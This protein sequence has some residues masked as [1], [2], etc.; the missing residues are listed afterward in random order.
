[1]IYH[2]S[3]KNSSFLLFRFF[4]F[5]FLFFLCKILGFFLW[6]CFIFFILKNLK[7]KK[8]NTTVVPLWLNERNPLH[9][10]LFSLS[11]T[12]QV[13]S[14]GWPIVGFIVILIVLSNKNQAWIN[15]VCI[16]MSDCYCSCKANSYNVVCKTSAYLSSCFKLV[17]FFLLK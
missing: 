15:S 6:L 11:F 2:F 8:K 13:L 16:H 7:K 3:G 1:M 17:A 12:F 9:F 5:F 10:F 14:I 4:F